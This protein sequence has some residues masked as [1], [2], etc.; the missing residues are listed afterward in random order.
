MEQVV[1]TPTD[2]PAANPAR[3]VEELAAALSDEVA[4][5]VRQQVGQLIEAQ[6]RLASGA[7]FAPDQVSEVY[8]VAAAHDPGLLSSGQEIERYETE[9]RR[10]A[11]TRLIALG[12]DGVRLTGMPELSGMVADIVEALGLDV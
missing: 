8:A 2:L 5:T 3:L 7:P 9:R 12:A 1:L 6:V 10:A 11:R 4:L